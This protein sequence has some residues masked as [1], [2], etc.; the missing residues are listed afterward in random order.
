MACARYEAPPTFLRSWLGTQEPAK[1][2]R[3]AEKLRACSSSLG[4]G[5]KKRAQCR[6][7]HPLPTVTEWSGRPGDLHWDG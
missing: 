2:I 5:K 6:K 3:G 4:H 1:F 7:P